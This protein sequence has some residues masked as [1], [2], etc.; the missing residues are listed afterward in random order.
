V[1]ADHSHPRLINSLNPIRI[2]LQPLPEGDGKKKGPNR[3]RKGK[4]SNQ[5]G[6]SPGNGAPIHQPPNR[7]RRKPAILI[8][9]RSAAVSSSTNRSNSQISTDSILSHAS[10]PVFNTA[11]LRKMRIA[12]PERLVI[13]EYRLPG[14]YPR[15]HPIFEVIRPN[16]AKS[17]IKNKLHG[18]TGVPPVS[19]L[20]WSL[21][22]RQWTAPQVL[23]IQPRSNQIAP[24]PRETFAPPTLNTHHSSPDTFAR[25]SLS[26]GA[27]HSNVN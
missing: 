18:R 17:D 10:R 4:M 19:T 13:R 11:T 23:I 2:V 3:M 1:L 8:L 14:F 12:V 16:P 22:F 7:T 21:D 20:P 26:L 5:A 25:I 27:L 15:K 6:S 9:C 24:N